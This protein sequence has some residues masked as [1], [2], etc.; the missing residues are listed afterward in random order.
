MDSL[1]DYLKTVIKGMRATESKYA[2][3]MHPNLKTHPIPYFGDIESTRVLTV[4][5]AKRYNLEEMLATIT[6]ENLHGEIDWGPPV[7]KEVW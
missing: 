1:E 6:P 5:D 2:I 3:L 4:P 7:G